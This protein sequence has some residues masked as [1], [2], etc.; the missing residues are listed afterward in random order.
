MTGAVRRI[1][2]WSGPRNISTALLRSWGNRPDTFVCDEP[3]YAH[4]LLKTG[5]PHP[6]A[7]EVIRWQENDWRKVAAWLTGD[8]PGGKRIFYQKHMTHHLLPEIDRGW[9]GRVSNAFLIRDPREVVP[10][11][12]RVIPNPRLA[13]TG[14]PQQLEIFRLVRGSPVPPVTDAR[15]VLEDPAR[16]LR[17]LCEALNVDFT[18]AMLSW[19]AGPRDTDGVWAKYWYDAVLKSTTFEPYRPKNNPVPSHLAG[20]VEEAGE[21]YRQLHEHRLGQ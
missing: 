3:L 8:V 20:L 10:S 16:Q 14:L 6:G 9:L 12:A 7:D 2:M 4:Y 18:E 17:L 19:P 13:D 11:L 21:I 5:A 15:D 1:A